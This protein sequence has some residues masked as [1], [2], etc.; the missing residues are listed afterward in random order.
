MTANH[1]QGK[2]PEKTRTHK[3]SRCG[4]SNNSAATGRST[5]KAKN[6]PPTHTAAATTCNIK[7]KVIAYS[8]S[9]TM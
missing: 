2:N 4:G 8:F 3:L 6:M 7:A 9:F 5:I 1:T